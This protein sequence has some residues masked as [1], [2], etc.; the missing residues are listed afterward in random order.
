VTIKRCQPGNRGGFWGVYADAEGD[1]VRHADHAEALAEAE[2]KAAGY[3]ALYLHLLHGGGGE[4]SQKRHAA[5][6]AREAK[7]V[8]RVA[9]LRAGLQQAASP[10]AARCHGY[11][12][13]KDAQRVLLADDALAP[14]PPGRHAIVRTTA[15]GV[16]T[17]QD[18]G[19]S[20]PAGELP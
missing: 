3:E 11:W 7:L 16:S 12:N 4:A 14:C 15:E 17:C 20:G 18:C 19:A 6:L 8:E 1:Y 9:K 2:K 13:A 10:G 5:S